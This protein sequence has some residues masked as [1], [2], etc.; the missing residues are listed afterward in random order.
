MANANRSNCLNSMHWQIENVLKIIHLCILGQVWDANNATQKINTEWLWMIAIANAENTNKMSAI[1]LECYSVSVS[2]TR[3]FASWFPV[4]TSL[5]INA[6][7][8]QKNATGE[9]NGQGVWL[10]AIAN[11]SFSRISPLKTVSSRGV[12]ST[13]EKS[14]VWRRCHVKIFFRKTNASSTTAS[15][16]LINA[17]HMIALV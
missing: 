6:R 5:H 11:N 7:I 1:R 10:R 3:L 9:D 12:H 4:K 8:Y 17:L 16:R 15:G 2:G 13:K 14:N